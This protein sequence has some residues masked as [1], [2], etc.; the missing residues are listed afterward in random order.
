M[1][2][3][4][5]TIVLAFGLITLFGII[6]ILMELAYKNLEHKFDR[7]QGLEN[8]LAL[9][10]NRINEARI[11]EGKEIKKRFEAIEEKI[12]ALLQPE[13]PHKELAKERVHAHVH[14]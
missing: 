9:H 14:K 8:T 1:E 10:V 2:I 6:V 12:E 4:D 3:F 11:A 7:L 5:Q 13:G